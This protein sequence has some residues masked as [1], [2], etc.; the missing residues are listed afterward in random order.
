MKIVRSLHR[1]DARVRCGSVDLIHGVGGHG[2]QEFVAGFEK[3]L[4]EDV[5]RFV[6]AVG[7]RD[8]FGAQAEMRGHDGFD[9]LALGIA[10]ER[11]GGNLRQRFAHAR[12]ALESVLVKVEPHGFAAA[13]RRVVLLHLLHASARGGDCFRG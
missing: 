6:H 11:A 10:R 3:C 8:L 13:E 7:E 9:R 5:N 4:E 1:D 12:R 2:Q